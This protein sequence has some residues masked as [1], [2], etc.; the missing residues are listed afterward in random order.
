M[1]QIV[2]PIHALLN[3]IFPKKCIFCGAT[4]TMAASL[5]IC[6]DC[7]S[8]IPYYKGEYL[9]EEGRAGGA[10]E[11][12]VGGSLYCNRIICALKYAGAARRAISGFK[13]H[14]R[15]EYGLTL[16]ALLCERIIGVYGPTAICDAFD[17]VTCVPLSH[18]RL[19]E[20]GY[21]QAAILA[22][23]TARYLNLPFEGGLL[24]RDSRGL[25]QSSLKREERRAN[26]RSSFH[27]NKDKAY[28][29]HAR[30]RQR[31]G[32]TNNQLLVGAMG[33]MLREEVTD[34]QPLALVRIILIDD[35]AT[36]MST[37]NACAAALKAAGAYEVTGAV[38]AAP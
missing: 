29:I 7:A 9:F 1:I 3:A 11:G 13:F 38:L 22:E 21:N 5:C 15:R 32:A 31:G 35:V 10:G 20:R 8:H 26:V 17:F 19:R 30:M 37:I 23:Y 12:G 18:G 4:L 2:R 28:E 33:D 14:G 25:R 24:E 34:N 36:S 6:D 16:A 27:V